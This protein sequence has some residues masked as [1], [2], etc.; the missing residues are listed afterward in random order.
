[1][2]YLEE[3][4]GRGRVLHNLDRVEGRV[5]AIEQGHAMLRGVKIRSAGKYG[6]SV[7][8]NACWLEGSHILQSSLFKLRWE[9]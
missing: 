5:C 3:R 6:G 4:E 7:A 8:K 1:M 9:F 2:Y